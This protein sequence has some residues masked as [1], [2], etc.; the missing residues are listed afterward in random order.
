MADPR[1]EEEK[2]IG[3]VNNNLEPDDQTKPYGSSVSENP[4]SPNGTHP[5]ENGNGTRA[6]S[7]RTSR[8]TLVRRLVSLLSLFLNAFI[9][10]SF[11]LMKQTQ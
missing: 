5:N 9:R 6:A 10:L 1:G 4:G 3:I 7:A 11:I 8:S 2:N